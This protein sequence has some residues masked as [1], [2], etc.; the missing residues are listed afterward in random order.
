MSQSSTHARAMSPKVEDQ[1]DPMGPLSPIEEAG[2]IPAPGGDSDAELGEGRGE[3]RR[4]MDG[5]RSR[6]QSRPGYGPV[7]RTQGKALAHYGGVRGGS[8]LCG[9]CSQDMPNKDASKCPWCKYPT[10]LICFGEF[11]WNGRRWRK[12]CIRCVNSLVHAR[13]QLPWK[14][15]VLGQMV[16]QGISRRKKPRKTF[17]RWRFDHGRRTRCGI[18]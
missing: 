11:V 3:L 8:S 13:E 16:S 17:W 4:D 10:H 2:E 14:L 9:A 6:S 15:Q 7:G 12:L 1:S 18:F 5:R